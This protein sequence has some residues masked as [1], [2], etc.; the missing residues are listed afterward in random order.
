MNELDQR[1][2]PF[3]DASAAFGD[4]A[5]AAPVNYGYPGVVR[6]PLASIIAPELLPVDH[7]PFDVAPRYKNPLAQRQHERIMEKTDPVAQRLRQIV[8]LDGERYQTFLERMVRSGSTL[9]SDAITGKQPYETRAGLPGGLPE[10]A[11]EVDIEPNWLGGKLGMT[12]K[13]TAPGPHSEIGRA[14]DM[15][16]MAVAG[17]LAAGRG[18]AT[19]GSGAVM[20]D[21]YLLP[22]LKVDGRVYKGG[23]KDTHSDIFPATPRGW[24]DEAWTNAVSDARNAGFV[25]HKGQFLKGQRAA[26]YAIENELINPRYNQAVLNGGLTSEHLLSDSGTPGSGIAA[27]ANSG[28]IAPPFFSAVEHAINTAKAEKMTPEQWAGYLKNQPGIKAEELT[29]MGLDDP[30]AFGAGKKILTRQELLDHAQEHGVQI[31]EVRKDKQEGGALNENEYYDML[32]D[33][34]HEAMLADYP[35]RPRESIAAYERRTGQVREHYTE[36]AADQL[37]AEGILHPDDVPPGGAKFSEYQ[38]PGGENYREMLFTLPDKASDVAKVTQR[39]DGKW[40][41]EGAGE[42]DRFGFSTREKALEAVNKQEQRPAQRYLSSHWDEPNVL[43]HVRM[44]DRIIPEG[45]QSAPRT[46]LTEAEIAKEVNER[47]LSKDPEA[48][49][50]YNVSWE[51]MDGATKQK[52]RDY[53]RSEA[54]WDEYKGLKTLHLE[55]L[56]SDWHQAGRKSGYQGDKQISPHDR[57]LARIK[58]EFEKNWVGKP[59]PG[60]GRVPSQWE[61]AFLESTEGRKLYDRFIMEETKSANIDDVADRGGGVKVPDA[62]FKTTWPDLVLKRMIREASQNGYDAISWT[63]GEAQSKRYDLSHKISEIHYN[64]ETQRLVAK[65]HGG[66]NVM[67][68]NSITPERLVDYVG[69]DLAEKVMAQEPS[70]NGLHS[71]K[72]DEVKVESKGMRLFYDKMLVDKANA[73]AK[74]FGGKVEKQKL[75]GYEIDEHGPADKKFRVWAEGPDEYMKMPLH[76]FATREDAEAWVRTAPKHE[77]HVLRLPPSLKDTA[78]RKGFPLFAAGLPFLFTPVDHDPFDSKVERSRQDREQDQI[79]FQ[80]LQRRLQNGDPITPEAAKW[81]E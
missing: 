7:D 79:K 70:T 37:A 38:L 4:Y 78:V 66:R 8:G 46:N 15:S 67:D 22:A 57:A 41:T 71:L 76:Q 69:K 60:S 73:I 16:G 11:T 26:E 50:R 12:S 51:T 75:G 44:N 80:N 20:P 24:T 55:E 30:K 53:L 21:R 58:E 65:D 36:A 34:A 32:N 17:P 64:P 2:D 1:L 77:I 28:K 6:N 54:T 63:P 74:K 31:K 72:G 33:R 13:W 68:Q 10:G 14:Q 52:W 43:A 35:K 49:S 56:Q 47:V 39:A 61:P 9:A 81:L 29:W 45:P 48:Q 3:A 27:V 42:A 18:A 40:Q 62:P 25:N 19:L 59:I 5:A 23:L